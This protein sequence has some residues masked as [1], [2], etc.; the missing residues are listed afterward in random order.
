VSCFDVRVFAIRRRPGRKAFEV[1]WRAGGR[2]RP[3][4]FATRALADS[5]RAELVR[6]MRRGQAFDPATGEPAAL[7]APVMVSWYEHAIAYAEVQ[8]LHLAPHSRG[9]GEDVIWTAWI[10]SRMSFAQ[11]VV[12]QGAA[13]PG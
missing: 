13:T 10:L 3:R 2:D 12:I 8:W 7:T 4:S 6:A 11:L 1:R 9:S 5:Y